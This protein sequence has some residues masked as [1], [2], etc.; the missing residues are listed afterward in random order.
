MKIFLHI[1]G[2]I[3]GEITEK[4]NDVKEAL[5][6][7]I[8]SYTKRFNNI[9][10]NTN[11]RY[12]DLQLDVISLD[13]DKRDKNLIIMKFITNEY[14]LLDTLESRLFVVEGDCTEMVKSGGTIK[15]QY[16]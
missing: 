1:W 4:A 12:D 2:L 9:I 15:N 8:E 13:I 5:L 11:F 16:L 7:H 14:T 6:Y 3:G 10:P